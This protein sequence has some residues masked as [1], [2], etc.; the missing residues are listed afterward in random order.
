MPQYGVNIR[1]QRIAA[2]AVR[3]VDASGVCVVVTAPDA[4]VTGKFGRNGEIRYNHPFLLTRRTD[5][6]EDDL[7][8][9]G[10]APWVLDS[11]FAQGNTKVAMVIVE[12][13]QDRAAI[14]AHEFDV[15]A[16]ADYTNAATWT[17]LAGKHWTLA[18]ISGTKYLLVKGN[19]VTD[20]TALEGLAV[21]RE[22]SVEPS[23]GGTEITRFTVAGSYDSTNRRLPIEDFD[24]TGLSAGTDYD[25]EAVAVTAQVGK[26]LTRVNA[27]GDSSEHTGI[28][29][30]L[31]VNSVHGFKPRWL[32]CP[33][34]DTGSR[35][36][37][38]ANG[39]AAAMV[40]VAERLRAMTAIDGPNT[41][42][43]DVIT[44]IGD[45][46]SDRAIVI[47]PAA[48]IQGE[49][50]NP[51]ERAMSGFAVGAI[52]RNDYENGWWSPPSNTP[53]FGIVGTARPI[54]AG[55]A[56]SRAQLML[57]NAIWTVTNENGG[58]ILTGTDTPATTDPEYSFPNVRRTIDIVAD[59]LRQAH[60]WAVAEGI[61]KT[62]VSA[63]TQS[64]N[65][66]IRG[67]VRKD[68]LTGGLC[69]ADPG[70]NTPA[71]IQQGLVEFNLEL[72][73]IY[74]ANSITFNLQLTP[75]YLTEIFA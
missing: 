25:L 31:D 39:L 34:L 40:I 26:D 24:T 7:G 19:N 64:V 68:A 44:Y 45:F 50:G 36:G 33:G 51:V 18:E 62:Y 58:F 12:E 28:Y 72:T 1:E 35:P 67:L 10:T 20:T 21:G 2:P 3:E 65:D 4:D 63:V 57:D 13:E 42:H 52:V 30:A 49:D 66:F 47:D 48:L 37:D 70:S 6:P 55:E 53:I 46:D 60:Q 61:T 27:T 75:K 29:A 69:Y 22:I 54:D 41:N 56:S 32:C 17:A 11:I 23:G 16:Y 71:E 43:A 5:A 8:D 9:T 74:P 15:E 14:A 73:P 59:S 38:A